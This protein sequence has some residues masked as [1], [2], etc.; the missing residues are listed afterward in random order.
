MKI[1]ALAA[2]LV[3]GGLVVVVAGDPPD[4]GPDQGGPTTRTC[5]AARPLLERVW[6]GYVPGR[7]GDILAVER[8]PHQ[9]GTRHSTPYPYTQDVPLV[10]Y[11]P[12]F[13]RGG[14]VS[15]R[16]VTVA[17]L[18]PTFAELLGFDGYPRGDGT[19]LS[20]ALLPEQSRNGV[21]RLIF[22]A[23][24]DGGGDNVLEQWPGSWPRLQSLM[25]RG[26]AYTRA[27]VG[28]SPSITPSI[29]ATIGTGT[30]PSSHGLADIK[31]RVGN[32]IVDAWPQISPRYLRVKT[33][34]DRW[35][36]ANGNKPLIGLLARDAWHLGMIGHGA[37]L[38]GGDKDIAVLD[39]LEGTEFET[40]HDLYAMPSYVLG[41]EGLLHAIE[42]VD[43]RDGRADG[44]WLGNPLLPIDGRIRSTPAWSIFQT[45][46][47]IQI[48]S[49]ESFG[50]DRIPDL[51]FTN[52]KSTDL[53]GHAWNMTRAEVRDDLEEQDRQLA[54]LVA[55]LNRLVGRR[56]YVLAV[57]ADHGMAPY[58]ADAG[59]WSIDVREMAEDIEK[60]FGGDTEEGR[61]VLT[62]RGY[63]VVLD[64]KEL[65][66]RGLTSADVALFVRNYRIEDNVTSSSRDTF[67]R[68]FEPRGNER[69]YL[70]ALTPEGLRDA[71]SCGDEKKAAVP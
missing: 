70:T 32:R 23:V 3:V 37:A 46:R 43:L 11:G 39:D 13:I 31:M 61:L 34:A 42:E 68:F 20:E 29:H 65:A 6:R 28:S 7:S 8:R 44:S 1:A 57:T 21:P 12:G 22:T 2:L 35:D 67:E 18:A 62:N 5:S 58:P 10:L 4:D 45:Q 52:Y 47:I 49:R 24:W 36:A 56:N 26:T 64:R 59:G 15:S 48:L 9:F 55:A 60:R 54:F 17:D 38:P 66:R 33:L 30:F 53:A 27:T 63:Q 51:F 41:H 71:L 50:A 40:N 19:V 25:K 16:P 69:L 14:S